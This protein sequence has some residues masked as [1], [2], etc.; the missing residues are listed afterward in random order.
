MSLVVARWHCCC[1]R[2]LTD[3]G[4]VVVKFEVDIRCENYLSCSISCF[5]FW[6][7]YDVE[8]WRS[9]QILLLCSDVAS[10]DTNLGKKMYLE[11]NM[12][13]LICQTR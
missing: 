2:Q 9:D 4:G 10:E 11:C 8:E 3:S 5:G 7:T 1:V 13:V 12:Q 6:D